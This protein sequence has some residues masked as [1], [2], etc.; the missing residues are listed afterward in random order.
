M[1]EENMDPVMQM[2][3]DTVHSCSAC[4]LGLLYTVWTRHTKDSESQQ[5]VLG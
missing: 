4:S 1:V 3:I 5:K 2:Q